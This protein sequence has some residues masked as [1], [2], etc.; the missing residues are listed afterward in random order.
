MRRRGGL[1]KIGVLAIAL[2]LAMGALGTSYGAWV[3]E[4]YI[5]GSFSTSGVNTT[6]ACGGHSPEVSCGTSD[7]TLNITVTDAPPDGYYC[8]FTLDNTAA[9]TLPV[10][11]N[12]VNLS[13]VPS[14][15]SVSV[16]ASLTGYVIDAGDTLSDTIGITLTE[17]Y[18]DSSGSFNV[19]FNIVRWN[20]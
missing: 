12:S 7:M 15:F 11:I 14:G 20:E 10:K 6:L 13:G 4:I 3:D 17:D 16:P 19:T 9:G 18:S 2:L 5:E 8:N 1:N